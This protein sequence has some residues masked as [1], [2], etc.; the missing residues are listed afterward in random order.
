MLLANTSYERYSSDIA[1]SPI[2]RQDSEYEIG[3]SLVYHF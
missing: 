3:L 1:E 2:V